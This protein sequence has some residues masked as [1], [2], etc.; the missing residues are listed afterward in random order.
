MVFEG[1]RIGI[2]TV[3]KGMDFVTPRHWK[4]ML[5]RKLSFSVFGTWTMRGAGSQPFP[6]LYLYF[7]IFTSLSGMLR[8]SFAEMVFHNDN[9]FF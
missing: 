1:F 6:F 2:I 8:R 9:V 7:F 5:V 4:I 3:L